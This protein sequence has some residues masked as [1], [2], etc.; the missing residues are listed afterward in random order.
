LANPKTENGSGYA[1]SHP[2]SSKSNTTGDAHKGKL[3][4]S[5]F[6][7]IPY[8]ITTETQKNRKSK[9]EREKEKGG[10]FPPIKNVE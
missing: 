8:C 2:D 9:R 7:I 4:T 6:V 5:F 10:G 1:S 3:F